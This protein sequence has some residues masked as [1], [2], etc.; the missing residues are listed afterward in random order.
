VIVVVDSNAPG[1]WDNAGTELTAMMSE[2]R[3]TGLQIASN[4]ERH[5]V[6]HAVQSRL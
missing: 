3:A 4:C 5:Y 1:S 6:N 2:V